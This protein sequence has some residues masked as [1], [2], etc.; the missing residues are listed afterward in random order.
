MFISV[1][2]IS[3]SAVSAENA[4]DTTDMTIDENVH[5]NVLYSA[6][7]T[8]KETDY[9]TKE[10]TP[11]NKKTSK[12]SIDSQTIKYA[13]LTEFSA[14]VTDSDG[15][16]INE[17]RVVFKIN[18]NTIGV[19]DVRDGLAEMRYH[20]DDMT[21]KEYTLTA[22]YGENSHYLESSINTTLTLLKHDSEITVNNASV[23]T[24]N[25]VKLT[26]T[27]TDT[28]LWGFAQS[29]KVAFKI[30]GKTIGYANVTDGVATYSYN[31]TKL[32]AKLYNIT[33]T[34]GGNRL[35][36]SDVSGVS[37]LNVSAIPTKMTVSQVSGYS[38]SVVLKA[39]VV[40]KSNSKYLPSGLV[41]FKVNGKTIGNATLSDGK[42]SLTYNTTQLAR[43]NYKISAILKPTSTYASSEASNNLTI[44]AEDYFTF[45][46]IKAAAVNVRNQFESNH[47]ITTVYIGKSRIALS[48]FLALMIQTVKNVNNG[49]GSA[50]VPY[51]HYRT[52]TTQ[53][54]SLTTGVFTIKQ[55]LDVGDKV[56][57]YM[58]TNN[59][60]PTSVSSALGTIGYFNVVYTYTRVLEVSESSYLVSTCRAYNWNTIHPAKS[61]SRKIYLTSD[62]IHNK[63]K[64]YALMNSIKSKLESYGYKV[65]IGGYG[66]NSHCSDIWDQSLPVNAVQVSIF[67]GADPGVIYDICTR[68]FMKTKENRLIYLVFNSNTSRDIT[69]LEFL[70][71]A[72]DDNYS[73][74]SFTG[75]SHPDVYLRDHGYDYVFTNNVDTIVK[76]IINYIS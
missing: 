46:Q 41:V 55:V 74:S 28:D 7:M 17:G 38:T 19:P 50:N 76:G 29:G 40:E 72:K 6:E 8:N 65:E 62:V 35:L 69:N 68:S 13:S 4:T 10:S 16:K 53:K 48:E 5:E 36:N 57:S 32:S 54:D 27:V 58:Q 63:D 60:P 37:Y 12:I 23:I 59:I 64:D 31:T 14:K 66:P 21:P 56:Y 47:E 44:K 51:K 22:K 9:V 2:F 61:T 70:K 43:G 26:A 1:M 15:K 45:K 11:T 20:L 67:G 30:N 25:T 73:P 18:G 34:F 39:T 42:A 52:L 71:R 49:K 33:A 24:Q 75:I 3:I